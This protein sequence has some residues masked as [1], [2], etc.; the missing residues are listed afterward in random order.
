MDL[1]VCLEVAS[2]TYSGVG[3]AGPEPSLL[4]TLT[5]ELAREKGAGR[6]SLLAEEDEVLEAEVNS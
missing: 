1:V 5:S 6:C 3:E 2:Y 4:S